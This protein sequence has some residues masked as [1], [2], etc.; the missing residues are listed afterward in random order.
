MVIIGRN[1]GLADITADA[2]GTVAVGANSLQALTSGEGNTAV[3][4]Q[5]LDAEDDGDFNTAVG[6]QALSAQ[7]GT[8]G[9]VAN[10]AVGYQAGSGLTTATGTTAIGYKAGGAATLTGNVNTLIG[11]MAGSAITSGAYNTIVGAD[12]GDAFTTGDKNTAVGYRAMG[13]ADGEEDDNTAVGEAALGQLSGDAAEDNVAVGKE[14]GWNLTTGNSNTI[15]GATSQPSGG[16]AVNQTVVGH[17][18]TGQADNSVTLGNGNVT[19]VYM[20]DEEQAT[21]NCTGIKNKY[22]AAVSVST[23]ATAISVASSYGGLAMV[24]MNSGGNISH[25]LVSYSLSG[26]DLIA[27]QTISGSAAGRTYSA[28]SGVLKVAMASGT[29]DVYATEI[30]VS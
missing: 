11:S 1:A 9:T 30:R 14:A 10:T 6:Y 12:A 5:A 13:A 8:S 22:R 15:I 27:T 17:G 24:W 18:A 16:G 21:V 28:V 2:A 23:S 3:G 7:T 19:A 25:D 26:V 29:Y 20:G 4:Y